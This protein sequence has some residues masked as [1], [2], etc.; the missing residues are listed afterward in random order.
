MSEGTQDTHTLQ[1]ISLKHRPPFRLGTTSFIYPAGW[2]QN[3]ARLA[4]Y[5]DEVELLFLESQAPSSLPDG[6]EMQRLADLAAQSGLTYTVHLPM[7]LDLGSE[8][9]VERRRAVDTIAGIVADTAGLPVT[10]YTLHLSY[11]PSA[12]RTQAEIQ[13]WQT[14][15]RGGLE[16]LLDAGVASRA[17]SIETLDYP[18]EWVFPLV[19][20]LDLRVCL[21]IGHLIIY[22]YDLP[23]ALDRY[24]ARTTVIHLHGV[25]AGR[26]HRPRDHRPLD[27]LEAGLLDLILDRLRQHD[28]R[29]SLSLE[30]FGIQALER[31]LACFASA[32]DKIAK[33]L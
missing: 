7:D 4:P 11:P 19:E 30:V 22:G 17:L 32:W 8:D 20:D 6:A 15:T 5:L 9:G 26:D 3:V 10:S 28:F 29:D 1:Q 27:R 12:P 24:L 25:A 14:R 31:S 13:H 33:T 16:S 18:Y 21:D 2:A 23:E